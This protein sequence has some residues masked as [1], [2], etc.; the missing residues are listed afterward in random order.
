[1]IMPIKWNAEKNRWCV[2][3]DA[4]KELWAATKYADAVTFAEDY[5]KQQE[6]AAQGINQG[7]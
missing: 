2:Y 7:L 6:T 4:G 1:M 3:D 5:A